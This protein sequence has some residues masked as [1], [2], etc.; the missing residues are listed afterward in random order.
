[1]SKA[2]S[3]IDIIGAG[4]FIEY[5]SSEGYGAGGNVQDILADI[6]SGPFGCACEGCTE[7]RLERI[8]RS[9]LFV[10]CRACGNV[11]I[12]RNRA[13]GLCAVC[14]ALHGHE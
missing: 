12:P 9:G 6:P 5:I 1:M 2:R 7:K 14:E 13:S 8:Q 3:S 11:P 4:V 10:T